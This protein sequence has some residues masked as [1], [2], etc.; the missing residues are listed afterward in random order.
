MWHRILFDGPSLLDE[1]LPETPPQRDAG[2][3]AHGAADGGQ[4]GHDLTA[5][6]QPHCLHAERI[7]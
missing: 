3:A 2:K 7:S 5:E 4:V 1:P 6:A